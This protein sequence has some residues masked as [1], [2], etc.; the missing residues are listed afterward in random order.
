M[1]IFVINPG[2]SSGANPEVGEVVDVTA[3][4]PHAKPRKEVEG[5]KTSC[6]NIIYSVK[7]LLHNRETGPELLQCDASVCRHC[8]VFRG[9]CR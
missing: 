7:F 2:A 5:R 9:S 1:E 4:V 3:K 8:C 6:V